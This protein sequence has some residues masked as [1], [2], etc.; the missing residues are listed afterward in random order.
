MRHMTDPQIHS[1]SVKHKIVLPIPTRCS[2]RFKTCSI[3]IFHIIRTH[4]YKQR[5]SFYTI[6][7]KFNNYPSHNPSPSLIHPFDPFSQHLPR[8]IHSP[9]P[10]PPFPS[11]PSLVFNTTQAAAPAL[12]IVPNLQSP[13]VANKLNPTGSGFPERIARGTLDPAS[14]ILASNANSTPYGCRRCRRYPPKA[15]FSQEEAL[16]PSPARGRGG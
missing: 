3:F 6:Q 8:Y 13:N 7:T 10:L 5:I 16:V 2:Q 4:T 15:Y 11:H 1:C 14:T 9:F 12:Q